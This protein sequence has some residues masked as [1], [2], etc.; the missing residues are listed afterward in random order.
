MESIQPG[1]LYRMLQIFSSK[2]TI[3]HDS[4]H[5][6]GMFFKVFLVMDV[7]SGKLSVFRIVLKKE[8]VSQVPA[9]NLAKKQPGSGQKSTRKMKSGSRPARSLKGRMF[10]VPLTGCPKAFEILH[11]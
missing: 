5:E 11:F 4:L 6:T 7:F 2:V 9:L 3:F 1:I 10:S 8:D